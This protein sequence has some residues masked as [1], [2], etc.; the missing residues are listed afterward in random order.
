MQ[1]EVIFRYQNK[2]VEADKKMQRQIRKSKKGSKK[3]KK[4]N[5]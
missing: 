3:A 4:I 2:D 5:Y 1:D